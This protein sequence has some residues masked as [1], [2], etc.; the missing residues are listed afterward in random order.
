MKIIPLLLILPLAA[1]GHYHRTELVAPPKDPQ[2]FEVDLAE[3]K[4]EAS[5][6]WHTAREKEENFAVDAAGFLLGPLGAVLMD[7]ATGPTREE[8]PD[9][10]KNTSQITDECMSGRGYDVVED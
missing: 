10:Y 5:Q 1:C 3:C 4:A 2:Q 7:S 8:N 6:R 9:Y